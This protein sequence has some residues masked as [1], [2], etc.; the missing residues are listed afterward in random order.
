MILT[1]TLNPVIDTTFFVDEVRPAVYRTEARRVTHLMGGKGTNVARA[2]RIL[3][4]PTTALVVLGGRLGRFGAEL[5]AEEVGAHGGAPSVGAHGGAPP[6]HGGAPTHGGAPLLQTVLAWVSGETRLMITIC[7]SH[8]RQQAFFAPN[9][10]FTAEDAATVRRVFAEA[11]SGATHRPP[12]PPSL[13]GTG[14]AYPPGLGGA[15]G[16][17]PDVLALCGS[18]PGPLADGLFPEFL[19]TGA[20]SGLLT[21]LDSSGAGLRHGLAAGPTIVKVNRAEAEG[22]LGRPLPT[23]AEQVAAVTELRQ[24]GARWAILTLGEQGA[25]LATDGGCWASRPP[26]VAAVNPIGSGDAMTA[27]LLTGVRRGLAPA[28]CLRL[29]TAVAAANT[30]TWDACRFAVEDV[31]RLLA[32]VEVVAL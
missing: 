16:R 10:P 21:L 29:G 27:G 30:L 22:L 4:E 15:G 19:R 20:E 17:G 23:M 32:E 3:G 1:V 9:E 7:D 2:L 13:G 6:A 11:M 28:E 31:S 8:N 26:A 24:R 12:D 14:A 18:S 25:I 5:L